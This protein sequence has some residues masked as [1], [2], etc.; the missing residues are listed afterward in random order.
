MGNAL[1][2]V[3]F[4]PHPASYSKEKKNLHFIKTK[5]GSTICGYFINNSA[6]ITILFSHGN[7]EDIGDLIPQFENRLK[8]LKLNMF[9]YDYSGYG[10][11]TG[12]PTETNIYNDVE[13][14]YNYLTNDLNVPKNSIIAYGRS[15]GSAASVHIATKKELLGLILQSPLSSIHR[16]KLRLKF[17]LPY[18]LFCN[19]DKIHLIKCPI[20]FI[21]GK[22]DK[23]ISFKGT[24]EMIQKTKVNTYYMLIEE[25]GHN[26]LDSSFGYKI[27]D[28]LV[29]FLYVLKNNIRENVNSVYD[30][31]NIN[32]NKLRNILTVNNKKKLKNN[33]KKKVVDYSENIELESNKLR[34]IKIINSSNTMDECCFNKSFS[35]LKSS[36]STIN[37]SKSINTILASIESIIKTIPE[38][39]FYDN[40]DS[41][42]NLKSFD[43]YVSYS[44]ENNSVDK[45]YIADHPY[46]NKCNQ[47]IKS[48]VKNNTI[49][50]NNSSVGISLRNDT[51]NIDNINISKNYVRKLKIKNDKCISIPDIKILNNNNKNSY[52]VEKMKK[53]KCDIPNIINDKK[54]NSLTKSNENSKDIIRGKNKLDDKY[55]GLYKI[56]SMCHINTHNV[57]YDNTKL[58]EKPI[59]LNKNSTCE[60][61]SSCLHEMNNLK[62]CKNDIHLKEKKNM[63][64]MDRIISPL[65]KDALS[66]GNII[67]KTNSLMNRSCSNENVLNLEN[68]IKTNKNDLKDYN[69]NSI[70]NEHKSN[71]LY[72]LSSTNVEGTSPIKN[73]S[74][75]IR[76]SKFE[77]TVKLDVKNSNS[78]SNIKEHD[79]ELEK[80][81]IDLNV[82]KIS[83]N[84]SNKSK[85]KNDNKLMDK[86]NE[87]D[88]KIDNINKTKNNINNG[89]NKIKR[90]LIL[91]TYKNN[92]YDYI[93]IEK[94]K[95]GSKNKNNSDCS[96]KPTNNKKKIQ[97]VYYR[98]K[99][100]ETFK[101]YSIKKKLNTILN[102]KIKNNNENESTRINKLFSEGVSFNHI[103]K[104]KSSNRLTKCIPIKEN[105]SSQGEEKNIEKEKK[106]NIIMKKGALV[107][108]I[109]QIIIENVSVLSKSEPII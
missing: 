53:I 46:N 88:M 37:S 64:C 44:Y 9:A 91:R 33:I 50:R 95:N 92:V 47:N 52:K 11:S 94:D 7:A 13:A 20:L 25:G 108:E 18:D 107:E 38:T 63:L 49:L 62:N 93:S 19:I 1:N 26:N 48:K 103:N 54:V 71:N 35:K 45:K 66:S 3:I 78:D 83:N 17:T 81:S 27:N 55:P 104:N 96:I 109:E 42:E 36:D 75:I 41:Y 12:I 85:E 32:V 102:N 72:R 21:H 34:N 28:A 58:Y 6:D 56:E 4:R 10:Q 43:S 87:V 86:K 40:Y 23:L 79:N 2:H 60:D 90:D 51:S 31:S 8:R 74:D 57:N 84:S 15:L 82:N 61:T 99:K 97:E 29:S 106:Y 39:T 68:N 5:H 65:K 16:V 73:N 14:A 76:G 100:M 77:Y 70:N 30:I 69:I 59:F 22:K 80:R 105:L 67:K 101:D 89:N 98:N 24:E